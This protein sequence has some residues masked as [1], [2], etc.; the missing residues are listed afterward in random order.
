LS[1]NPTAA[2]EKK[3]KKERL[4]KLAQI[5]FYT[6]LINPSTIDCLGFGA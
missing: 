4:V 1:S 6:F 5:Q 3:G 2:K